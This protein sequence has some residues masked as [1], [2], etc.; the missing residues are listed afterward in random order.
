MKI[1]LVSVGTFQEYIL[2]NIANLYLFNNKDITVITEKEY[3]QYFLKYNIELIDKNELNDLN[4]NNNSKLNGFW[5]L[6][7][8]RLFYLYSY[9]EKYNINNCV[10]IEND[11]LIY[12][13]FNNIQFNKDKICA[14]FDCNYRVIP[15]IIYIPIPSKL[16]YILDNYNVNDNDMVNLGR[17]NED[18][19]ERLPIFNLPYN[20]DDKHMLT[21]NFEKYDIIFDAA[22]I[23]QFLGGVDPNNIQGDSRGFINETCLI[24]YNNYTF[25]WKIIGNVYC[26]FIQIGD[27]YVRIF[28][29]H[30]HC[31]NLKL[32]M[33]N[34]PLE[35]KYI[36]IEK[37]Y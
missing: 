23:G 9:I 6:C 27:I 31:K 26:P 13:N 34:R 8:V 35:V 7:S 1:I 18:I 14:P 15:S 5:H 16:K 29:L 17:F 28:N 2:D 12:D 10:H 4:F 20:N 19:I 25:Y 36:S 30:I 33:A 3:F 22:A 21:K 32:F 24:K 11:V 37:I